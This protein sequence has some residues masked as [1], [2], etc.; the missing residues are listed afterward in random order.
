[1]SHSDLIVGFKRRLANYF[2][3]AGDALGTGSAKTSAMRHIF[4][5]LPTAYTTPEAQDTL[6]RF[7]SDRCGVPEAEAVEELDYVTARLERERRN[8][9]FEHLLQIW[10]SEQLEASLRLFFSENDP[11][12]L[13]AVSALVTF[14]R[15]REIITLIRELELQ[16][17]RPILLP[18]DEEDVAQEAS[19]MEMAAAATAQQQQQQDAASSANASKLEADGSDLAATDS[20]HLL[21]DR[22]ND[23]GDHN[24][25]DDLLND[26]SGASRQDHSTDDQH[27]HGSD[28]HSH[29]RGRPGGGGGG[30]VGGRSAAGPRGDGALRIRNNWEELTVD[31]MHE[32]ELEILN[33]LL[34]IRQELQ[35]RVAQ[36]QLVA[37]S[38]VA[39][40]SSSSAAPATLAAASA[41]SA[42]ASPA[43]TKKA[44][45]ATPGTKSPAPSSP[46]A[47]SPP[48]A[49]K[50]PPGN[51]SANGKAAAVPA[52]VVAEGDPQ[53]ASVLAAASAE[54]TEDLTQTV[55][56][57][58]RELAALP[59][60]RLQ[61]VEKMMHIIPLIAR[62]VTPIFKSQLLLY[63]GF[64]CSLR[65]EARKVVMKRLASSTDAP[66]KADENFARRVAALF[67][68][69]RDSR[70]EARTAE[71]R[72]WQQMDP[73]FYRERHMRLIETLLEEEQGRRGD[74]DF[75]EAC[76]ASVMR[77]KVRSLVWMEKTYRDLN[78]FADL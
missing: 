3:R 5:T 27:R 73:L 60:K 17:R 75:D 20:D 11:A 71:K 46:S 4:E 59:K 31:N 62:A 39:A 78:N 38:V 16:Y 64:Y 70:T 58:S 43:G 8:E 49:K 55:T 18:R 47:S 22:K 57:M 63:L 1:M 40:T 50:A 19:A 14:Y 7:I 68:Q 74:L 48:A 72:A 32:F 67:T 56:E 6:M 44:P 45:A 28:H 33:F 41:A 66:M 21:K 37:Q 2:E 69:E 51:T 30:R 29:H 76:V 42:P 25:D 26:A 10:T 36:A 52:A 12:Q 34:E 77:A 61:R 24:D 15:G 23:N 13:P 54:K 35:E 53:T 65:V 9:R